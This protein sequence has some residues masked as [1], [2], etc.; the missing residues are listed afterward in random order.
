MG[1]QALKLSSNV[2]NNLGLSLL[3]QAGVAIGLARY[4]FDRL[5]AISDEYPEAGEVGANVLA[6]VTVTTILFQII[7]PLSARFAITRAGEA[8]RDFEKPDIRTKPEVMPKF[9]YKIPKTIHHHN[10]LHLL[11]QYI[12]IWILLALS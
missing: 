4:L 1:S 8:G 9:A 3:S 11:K 5:N 6:T 10:T 12:N 7:G 2:K